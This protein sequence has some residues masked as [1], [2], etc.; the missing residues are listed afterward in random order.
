MVIKIYCLVNTNKWRD[1]N[2]NVIQVFKI[3]YENSYG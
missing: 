1:C 2:N 3:D